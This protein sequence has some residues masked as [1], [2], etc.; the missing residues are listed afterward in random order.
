MTLINDS[1][2][3]LREI[4]FFHIFNNDSCSLIHLLSVDKESDRFS[5]LKLS[6]SI[7][8]ISCKDAYLDR[9]KS[10]SSH[11]SL[12]INTNLNKTAFKRLWEIC[13]EIFKIEE[14][15]LEDFIKKEVAV[16]LREIVEDMKSS[17]SSN[18]TSEVKFSNASMFWYAINCC[19]SCKSF[20]IDSFKSSSMTV[21]YCWSIWASWSE[22]WL[23]IENS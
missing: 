16:L 17:S 23:K 6:F 2:V 15:W 8:S 13:S 19:S 9:D 3:T 4:F 12:M 20:K 10:T 1:L 21:V 11:Q 22:F 14:Q 7:W 18:F 5:S